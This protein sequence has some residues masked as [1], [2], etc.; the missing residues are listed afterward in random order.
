[1]KK[2]YEE[3][4]FEIVEIIDKDIITASVEGNYDKNGWQ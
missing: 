3:L 4:K 2:T 1:M